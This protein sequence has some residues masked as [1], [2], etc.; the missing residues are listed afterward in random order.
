MRKINDE[1]LMQ[2]LKEDRMTQKELAKHF[3]CSEPAITKRKK[4]F[5]KLGLLDD[6]GIPETFAKLDIGKQKFVIAKAEGKSHAEAAREAFACGTPASARTKGCELMKDSDIQRAFTEILHEEGLTRRYRIQ[7][8]KEHVD[9]RDP[10]VSLKALDQSFKLDGYVEKHVTLNVNYEDYKRDMADL[11]R[12]IE[13]LNG[14]LGISKDNSGELRGSGP[15][16]VQGN[17]L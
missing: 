15:A 17:G 4:R 10:N 6:R 14:E 11:N 9:H 7:R 2:L 8:L 1:E 13:E 12:E 5:E 16:E 3:G